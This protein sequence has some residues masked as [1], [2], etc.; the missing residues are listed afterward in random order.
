M[1][2]LII[3]L[4]LAVLLTNSVSAKTIEE[5]LYEGNNIEVPGHNLTLMGIGSNEKSI[6]MCINNKIYLID[7]GSRKELENLKIEP[8]RIYEDYIKLQITYSEDSLCDESCSNILCFRAQTQ[9]QENEST[10]QEITEPETQQEKKG[11]NPFSIIL[12]L[13][14]LILLIILLFKKKR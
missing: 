3:L 4:I 14:V 6:A 8:K 5:I 13:T 2:K 7:K 10:Q 9:P 11:I 12:F 1:K